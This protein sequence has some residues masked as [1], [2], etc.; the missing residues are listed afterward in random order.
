MIHVELLEYPTEKDWIE[1]KRRALVTIG[2]TTVVNPPTDEWKEKI[3]NACHSP[4]RYLRF[5]FYIECPS[6][7][8]THL[9]RHVHAQPYIKSQRN[10][11]QSEYD[12]NKAPQDTPV[13]MIYDVNAEELMNI[14]HKRL[15]RKASEETRELVYMMCYEVGNVCPEFKG[16]LVPNCQYLG[17]CPEMKTCGCEGV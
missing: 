7:V 15:C 16:F 13:C 12:R 2:K 5:S 14:A 6:W 4:I 1:V 8:A 11:R 17:R 3:L 10:D 9:A